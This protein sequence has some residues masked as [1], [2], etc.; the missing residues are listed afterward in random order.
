MRSHS[1]ASARISST[2]K[3][4]DPRRLALYVLTALDQGRK[5]LDSILDE[6]AAKAAR[7]SRRDQ[8]LFT[9]LV[10][11]VL[12]W[13]GRLDWFIG[14]FSKTPL[15]RM[16]PEILLI[17]RLGAFQILYLDRVPAS[18]AVHT[19][20]EMAKSKAAVWGVR[21]VNAVL[22]N[23]ARN[24][25]N[26]RFPDPEK[27]PVRALAAEKSFPEWL[28]ARW[29]N[30]FGYEETAAFCDAVNGIPPVTLRANT[31]RTGRDALAASLRD[32]AVR[33]EASAV[34]PEAVDLWNL[35]RPVH[36]LNPFIDGW[37]QVQDAAAQLV[38]LLV[39]PKPGEAILDACAGLGG[40]TGHL[41]QLMDNTGSVTAVDR[42]PHK[43]ERLAAEMK[44]LG[45]SCVKPLR[46]DWQAG[47]LQKGLFDRVLLDAPCSG[48]GVLRRNP[49]AKWTAAEKDLTTHSDRQR[50]LLA[51]AAA[52]VR[53]GGLLV[54]AVCST[55]PEETGSV[56]SR[57][58]TAHTDFFPDRTPGRLP[59]PAG[60]VLT[61]AG[62]L[63]TFPHRH[64]TDG[65]FAARLRR[66]VAQDP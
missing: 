66:S 1:R 53:P 31:L 51:Q 16:A 61:P 35:K 32:Q 48:L 18:A 7:L 38:S 5:T 56:V 19:S 58:L 57:F 22:R 46:H 29:L 33:V 21:F 43:L 42:D 63:L 25:Q 28:A 64:G 17:L 4:A 44:R 12:R 23:L 65:F 47:P 13:R 24:H 50:R 6:I 52:C 2:S 14:S 40:K 37:F 20:V 3:G 10:F 60:R 41:A 49:D 26:V 62:Y 11:G 9:A 55:E 30:R 27:D 15:P 59:E 39:D 36:Q 45:V 8:S 54:Y 34:A